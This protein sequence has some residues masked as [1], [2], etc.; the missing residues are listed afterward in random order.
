MTH[1]CIKYRLNADGT[2]P[3][4]LC[5]HP[6]GVGGVFGVATSGGTTQHDDT[7]FVGL[8][9]NDDYAPAELVPTQADLETYLTSVS[10]N[11]TQPDPTDPDTQVPFDPV[12]AAD[13]VWARL[14]ALNAA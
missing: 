14:E 8:S 2:V 4:L 7:V 12:A 3:A 1:Y 5:L 10:S 6:E 13:W 11:W 9:E